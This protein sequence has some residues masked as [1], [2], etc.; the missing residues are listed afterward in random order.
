[1]TTPSSTFEALRKREARTAA[2]IHGLDAKLA[3]LALA[4]QDR[5]I[6]LQNLRRELAQAFP[7]ASVAPA[8]HAQHN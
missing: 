7:A 1:M 5:A 3:R 6:A 8:A 2:M 4:R